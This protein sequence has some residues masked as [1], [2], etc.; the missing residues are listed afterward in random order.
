MSSSLAAENVKQELQ[1]FE[2]R[3]LL[4]AEIAGQCRTRLLLRAHRITPCREEAEDIV[5]EVY[6]KA[7]RGLSRFRGDSK[8]ETWLYSIMKNAALEHLRNSK[9][10]GLNR[11]ATLGS[12]NDNETILEVP[13]TRIDPEEACARSEME[14]ILLSEIDKLD[15]V[16]GRTVQMCFLDEIPYQA[17][18]ESLRVGVSTIKSRVF[19]CKRMLRK[20][21]SPCFVT[22]P[23][24]HDSVTDGSEDL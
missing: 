3:S 14:Q 20:T 24:Q 17:V 16:C 8:M 1:S 9:R 7:L 18:A 11:Q 15:S 2:K 4:F 19:R 12:G 13:D 5:Q 6:L 22:S 23:V 21:L 10:R